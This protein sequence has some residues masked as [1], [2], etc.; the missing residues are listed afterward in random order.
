MNHHKEA[1][2]RAEGLS[3][4]EG[5]NIMASYNRNSGEE[6]WAYIISSSTDSHQGAASILALA[7]ASEGFRR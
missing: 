3:S 7:T 5:Q 1:K 4:T 2:V 6:I